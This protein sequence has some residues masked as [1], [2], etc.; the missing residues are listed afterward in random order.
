MANSNFNIYFDGILIDE[1]TLDGAQDVVFTY[2]KQ[3]ASGE[4]G[5][6]YSQTLTMRGESY[7]DVKSKILDQPSPTL[8]SIDVL[9]QDKNISNS[10][11]SPYQWFTGK[12]QGAD[13]S[14]LPLECK[15]SA[16]II[17]NSEKAK[18]LLCL[19]NTLIWDKLEKYD[20][21]G[22]SDGE[23][24]YRQSRY[25]PYCV[26]SGASETLMI[27]GVIA[28]AI[29]LP[30]ALCVALIVEVINSMIKGINLIPGVSI[31]EIDFDGN[32]DTN[33]FEEVGELIA[34]LGDSVTG[35][36][37]KHKAP[38]VHS[39]FQN[40]CD[41]C[42]LTLSSSL[43][44]PN[45]YY[46]DAVR[47]DASLE[48]GGRNDE[49]IIA[50]FQKNKPN[51]TGTQFL[52]ELTG[53]WMQWELSGD[54][55]DILSIEPLNTATP[56][57][58]FDVSD[59]PSSKIEKLQYKILNNTPP[60]MG[61]FNFIKDGIDTAGDSV[62][63]N[64][65]DSVIDFNSPPISAQKGHLERSFTFGAARFRKD[66]QA[67]DKAAVDRGFFA[68]YYPSQLLAH[69][70]ALLL[71]R[72][73][74]SFPKLILIDAL[75]PQSAARTYKIER[76]DGLFD[77]CVPLWLREHYTDKNGVIVETLYNKVFHVFNPRTSGI[78]QR[79]FTLELIYDCDLLQ[80]KD[81]N[82]YI[83]LPNG[84]Q[85]FIEQIAITPSSGRMVISGK[86]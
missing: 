63:R 14:E 86:V 33:A 39:Y 71:G 57:K 44:E 6:S 60:A 59:L 38:Y 67:E 31:N 76:D 84:R 69:P 11:G 50:A 18:N 74:F 35:C 40:L 23:D 3:Q 49:A 13:I 24:T 65:T 61:M 79:D 64:W 47:L 73:T 29:V 12:I 19:K 34:Y 8:E 37:R 43:F 68:D 1:A 82:K 58:W 66:N 81:L 52:D 53:D 9:V 85:G 48:K 5:N 72:H 2:V 16:P 17:D 80:S 27:L 77:Y 83:G 10:D 25:I 28:Q 41:I 70:N 36:G 30:V 21:S 46:H 55:G 75:S 4:S 7:Q 78:K 54:N 45:G 42:G 15:A 51:L 20:G 32:D 56:E 62:N 26:D 22:L